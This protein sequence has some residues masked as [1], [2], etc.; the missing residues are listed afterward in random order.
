MIICSTVI[1]KPHLKRTR[2]LSSD[3]TLYQYNIDTLKPQLA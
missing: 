3:D 1:D 2:F